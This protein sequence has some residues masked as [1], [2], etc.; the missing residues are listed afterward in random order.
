MERGTGGEGESWV[1]HRSVVEPRVQETRRGL[2]TRTQDSRER[3]WGK[4]I[5]SSKEV[6]IRKLGM[7]NGR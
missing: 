6:F 2:N 7:M 4:L 1:S 5:P 3:G